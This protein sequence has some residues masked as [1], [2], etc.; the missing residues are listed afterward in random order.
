MAANTYSFTYT[1]T[2]SALEM[3]KRDNGCVR[4]SLIHYP[5]PLLTRDFYTE[6]YTEKKYDTIWVI[7][8]FITSCT[9]H[10]R[11]CLL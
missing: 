7:F 8:L 5:P 4:N 3:N 11:Q 10:D 2:S 9:L 6:D 1:V